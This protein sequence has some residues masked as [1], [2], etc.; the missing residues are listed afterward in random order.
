VRI[1]ERRQITIRGNSAFW[2]LAEGNYQGPG[3]VTQGWLQE[4]TVDI[5]DNESRAMTASKA[6]N[7]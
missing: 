6:M 7:L 4:T 3:N 1:V 2:V 5:Y